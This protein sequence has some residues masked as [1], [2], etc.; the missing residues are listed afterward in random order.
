MPKL[1][2]KEKYT[3]IEYLMHTNSVSHEAAVSMYESL[4]QKKRSKKLQEIKL[5]GKN[6]KNS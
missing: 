3:V 6:K 5:N 2:N 4:S 1:S